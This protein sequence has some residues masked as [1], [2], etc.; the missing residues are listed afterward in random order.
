MK[1]YRLSFTKE[2]YSETLIYS[3]RFVLQLRKTPSAT[4]RLWASSHSWRLDCKWIDECKI[5][6]MGRRWHS[7]GL[8]L[9]S[10]WSIV[11]VG[12]AL[13]S[14]DVSKLLRSDLRAR[15]HTPL[16]RMPLTML[17]L[18]LKGQKF[19]ISRTYWLT[20]VSRWSKIFSQKFV[21]WYRSNY[22]EH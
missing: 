14:V 20:L 11:K 16:R 10:D 4:I 21:I 8:A 15:Y 22:D 19:K 13:R 6:C 1:E 3:E 5:D 9:H 2:V 12:V 18:K 7:T 17:L